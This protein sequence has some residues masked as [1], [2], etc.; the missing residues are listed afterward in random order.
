M[1]GQL[2]ATERIRRLPVVTEI[3]IS[4]SERYFPVAATANSPVAADL[5][6]ERRDDP[7]R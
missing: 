1:C 6:L 4:E 3:R 7:A 2:Q 5:F